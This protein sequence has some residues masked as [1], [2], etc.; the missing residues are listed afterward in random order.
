LSDRETIEEQHQRRFFAFVPIFIVFVGQMVGAFLGAAFFPPE[1]AGF[2]IILYTALLLFGAGFI[3]GLNKTLAAAA[4]M[5]GG[6]MV[7]Y[8]LRFDEALIQQDALAESPL[9][10]I[11]IAAS[12]VLLGGLASWPFKRDRNPLEE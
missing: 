2:G 4:A 7:V 12:A 3:I 6:A 8:E 9:L 5:A 1:Y 11:V 10:R